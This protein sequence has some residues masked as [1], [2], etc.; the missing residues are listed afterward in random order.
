M[1]KTAARWPAL[2]VLRG[3]AILGTLATNLWVFTH[4]AGSIGD[5]DG[6]PP[7]DP[8]EIVL[9]QLSTGKF[10]GLLSLMFGIGLAIQCDS[11]RRA[12]RRWPGDYHWRALVLFVDGVLNYLLVLEFDVLMGYAASGV[13][14]AWLLLTSDR[15][16]WR[17][18][19]GLAAVHFAMLTTFC[20]A[21]HP[22]PPPAFAD[23]SAFAA[24][25]A[26]N[27]FRD[28]GWWEL[29]RFRVDNFAL[30]RT[31][32]PLMILPLTVAMF[33]LGARLLRAGVFAPEGARLRRRLM[34][35]AALALALDIAIALFAGMPWW[36]LTRWGTATVV[37]LG[38]LAAGAAFYQRRTPGWLGRRLAE[39][40]RTALS[41]YVLQNLLATAICYGWGLDLAGRID[42]SQRLPT[43]VLLYL[44]LC[45][46]LM[47][48]AHLWLR[49]F[50]RGP[51]EAVWAGA[52]GGLAR[53][54]AAAAG[55][56]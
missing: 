44:A 51:L 37:A 34:L 30:Y 48:A 36:F 39:V 52:H 47:L 8:L 41:C 50:D 18:L 49:R 1:S 28:A 11:A 22:F 31:V 3:I 6:P 29:V 23:P 7:T 4:P 17:W 5:F 40:G 9:R 38:I 2:D 56:P 15:A 16:Q 54:R 35:A 27:P 21:M 13:V 25:L 45:P 33:L 12:G 26:Y 10:L 43:T 14:V 46:L 24:S 32:E 53:R 42:E 20:I 55:A 19:L